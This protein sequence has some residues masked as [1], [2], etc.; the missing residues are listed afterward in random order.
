M[1][2]FEA[3]DAASKD[4][5]PQINLYNMPICKVGADRVLKVRPT[6]ICGK[7]VPAVDIRNNFETIL[8]EML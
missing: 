3:K 2:G 5:L 7:L 4:S 6:K 8:R 1:N